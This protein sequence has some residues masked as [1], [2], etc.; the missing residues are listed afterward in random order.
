MLSPDDEIVVYCSHEGC[1]ASKYAY[2]LLESKGY[3]NVRRY[4]GGID[5]WEESGLPLEGEWVK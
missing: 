2:H 1:A 3:G 4:S 5:E